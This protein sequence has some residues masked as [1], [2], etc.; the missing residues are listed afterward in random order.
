MVNF[1]GGEI[2]VL[3]FSSVPVGR[4]MGWGAIVL[5][6]VLV[7]VFIICLMLLRFRLRIFAPLTI[8]MA[9]GTTIHDHCGV[10]ECA[11]GQTHGQGIFKAVFHWISRF[12]KAL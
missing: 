1:A 7:L 12:N 4:C 3:M 11:K 2:P 9:P 6:F 5:M 8:Y 10:D